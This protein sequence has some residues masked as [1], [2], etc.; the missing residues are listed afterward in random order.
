[1]EVSLYAGLNF[2]DSNICP[3]FGGVRCIEI[4]VDGGSTV[5]F[6]C[7]D[8]YLYLYLYAT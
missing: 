6:F 1:M 2:W 3:L 7:Q 8:L 5:S 4:S